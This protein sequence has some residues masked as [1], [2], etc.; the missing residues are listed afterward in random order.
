[1]CEADDR[2]V[3]IGVSIA[4][5]APGFGPAR[6]IFPHHLERE[7]DV[8]TGEGFAIRAET[9]LRRRKVTVLPSG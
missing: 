5:I 9:P 7:L 1:M 4:T 6:M 3:C 2:G 8:C